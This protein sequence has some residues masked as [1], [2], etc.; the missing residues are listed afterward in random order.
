VKTVFQHQI[1]DRFRAEFFEAASGG[2]FVE[3]GANERQRGSQTWQF[4]QAEWNRVLVESQPDLTMQLRRTGRSHV[5]DMG[6]SSPASDGRAM[7]LYL[8]GPHSSLKPE[9]VVTG[10]VPH[11]A[12]DMLARFLTRSGYR[13]MR[14]TGLNGWHAPLSEAPRPLAQRANGAAR[15]QR[16]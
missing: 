1:E 9:L 6:C 8:V 16:L 14:R 11:G 4:E 7:R 5:F 13:L 15:G 2:Y 10:A 3:V 12:I